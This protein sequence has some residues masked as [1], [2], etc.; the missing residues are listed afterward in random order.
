METDLVILC[1]DGAWPQALRSMLGRHQSLGIRKIEVDW[2]TDPLR[3]SSPDAVELLRPYLHSS[4]YALVVRDF[5]G[6]G[7]KSRGLASLEAG[8]LEALRCS[9]WTAGRA[10]VI[11]AD[12]ELEGWLR[13]E[14][15]HIH[16]LLV[17]RARKNRTEIPAWKDKLREGYSLYQ[18]VEENGKARYPK[19]VFHHLLRYFAIP[20]SNAL[21]DFLGK[22]ESL[23]RC[24]VPSYAKFLQQMR[25]WFPAG[26]D[27]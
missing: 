23:R 27:A 26:S 20:P 14:S 24:V 10:E 7:W 13:L 18:G 9:G 5:H 12:P 22:R 17:E 16:S 11:I 4:Q 6:S 25:L 8:L 19:E 15:D 3:D 1:P 21:F 2:I